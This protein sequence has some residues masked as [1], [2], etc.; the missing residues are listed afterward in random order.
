M[1]RVSMDT[2]RTTPE[3]IAVYF[4]P[5][6]R[7]YRALRNNLYVSVFLGV[8]CGMAIDPRKT[9]ISVTVALIVGFCV[10]VLLVVRKKQ[11]QYSNGISIKS[12]S[13]SFSRADTV[14]KR[15]KEVFR[16][17][18][19]TVSTTAK[20]VVSTEPQLASDVPVSTVARLLAYETG[21]SAAEMMTL[22]S[23]TQSQ[24]IMRLPDNYAAL[25][26]SRSNVEEIISSHTEGKIRFSWSTTTNPRTVSWFPIMSGLPSMALFRDHLDEIQMAKPGTFA[27]GIKEDKGVYYADHN[28]ETPWHCRG[29][30]SG[31]GKSSGFLAKTAQICYNDPE[32]DIY[33]VDTKQISFEHVR[34]IRGVHVFDNPQSEMG[35]IWDM[36]YTVEGIMRDR[37]TAVR[38]KRA[39]ITEFNNIWMLVD[40]G[41]DLAGFLKSYYN[42]H[43]K[44]SGD[45]AQP[46]IWAE[47]IGPLLRLGRQAKIRGEMMFQDVTDRALG[48]ESLKMTFG[49]FGMAGY[50]KPQWERTIGPPYEPIMTGPGK[51]CMV[52]GRER[53]WVQ[54]FY[55]DPQYLRDYAMEN[56]KGKAV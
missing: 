19:T 16:R 20:P 39:K 47:C 9:V 3:G 34:G 5:S 1:K 53:T 25:T 44:K 6:K 48:G 45:P 35:K 56:R 22:L 21:C 4:S 40:E 37:Y 14:T 46:V 51:I 10:L 30:G 49:V 17:D 54:G 24:G 50:L 13:P 31:T 32:A 33:C 11:A 2:S 38:E 28:G 7:P 42:R 26:K 36:F 43:I 41:N 15:A 55:D 29:A 52:H 27:V 23:L 8:I 18:S 12:K